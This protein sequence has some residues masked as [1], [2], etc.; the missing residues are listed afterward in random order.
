[1]AAKAQ[2]N[3]VA[4]R[5]LSAGVRLFADKGYGPTSTRE[6][7]EA[8]GITKPMLYYYFGSKE[9]LCRAAVDHF[10]RDFR[11]RL[12]AV[13]DLRLAPEEELTEMVSQVF[14]FAQD[15][16]D[17][18]RVMLTL[19]YGPDGQA[20][21]LDLE[22]FGADIHEQIDLAVE[23]ACRAGFVRAG[24]DAAFAQAISG[25][26]FAWALESLGPRK[27]KLSRELAQQIVSDLLDGFRARPCAAN[28]RGG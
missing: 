1:M 20:P 19:A 15:H 26:V 7:A 18:A 11:A 10:V 23:R 21:G 22:K 28:G 27:A 3:A 4:E 12:E 14:Q 8:A 5:I 17:F 16:P 25:L 6:I 13:V 2:D 9:G 24:S